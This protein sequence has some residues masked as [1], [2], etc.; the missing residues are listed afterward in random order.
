MRWVAYAGQDPEELE[1]RALRADKEHAELLTVAE[2][3]AER[4]EGIREEVANS[5]AELLLGGLRAK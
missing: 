5:V 3:A 1:A 4:L 2:E